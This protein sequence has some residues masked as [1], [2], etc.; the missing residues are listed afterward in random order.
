MNKELNP[1]ERALK[2]EGDRMLDAIQQM[3]GKKSP[4]LGP[5]GQPLASSERKP[6]GE[7]AKDGEAPKSIVGSIVEESRK[8]REE[9]SKECLDLMN[10]DKNLSRC[11]GQVNMAYKLLYWLI[12]ELGTYP[13]VQPKHVEHLSASLRANALKGGF[14]VNEILT[15]IKTTTLPFLHEKI[16]FYAALKRQRDAQVRRIE[17]KIGKEGIKFPCFAM[18]TVFPSGF[19][20]GQMLVVYGPKE[21][22]KLALRMIRSANKADHVWLFDDGSQSGESR[23][24]PLSWWAGCAGESSRFKDVMRAV[25]GETA[26]L[27]VDD[28]SKIFDA[29]GY[30]A[31]VHQKA[32]AAARGLSEVLKWGYEQGISSI[33]GMFEED[34]AEA[35]PPNTIP[36]I[37]VRMQEKDGKQFLVI[38]SDF[39]EVKASAG[40]GDKGLPGG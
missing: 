17:K 21:A 24:C 30:S 6:E 37:A 33:V 9:L 23:T 20:P 13:G 28:V 14:N 40:Q 29:A 36:H 22:V 5:D 10:A 19:K 31:D 7:P 4:I 1:R 16:Q 32:E 12:Q 15:Q 11:T 18:S 35:P 3:S 34:G 2:A 38:G 8:R 27:I 26:L 39:L 25:D